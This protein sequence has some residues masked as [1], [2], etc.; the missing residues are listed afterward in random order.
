MPQPYTFPAIM[1]GL[2]LVFIVII[3]FGYVL[4]LFF[5]HIKE[6]REHPVARKHP[7]SE[8]RKP[9]NKTLDYLLSSDEVDT[10]KGQLQD[11]F[12][13]QVRNETLYLDEYEKALS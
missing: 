3:L 1:A 7:K 9:E 12:I 2:S 5:R 6:E 11:E 13:T 8:I 10:F 4:P